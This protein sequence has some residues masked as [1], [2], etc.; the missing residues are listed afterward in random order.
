MNGVVLLLLD[1]CGRN[2]FAIHASAFFTRWRRG[3]ASVTA[4]PSALVRADLAGTS[5]PTSRHDGFEWLCVLSGRLRVVLGEADLS[6]GVGEAV[7][8]DTQ[9]PYWFGS[10][11]DGPVEVLSIFGRPG[12]RVLLRGAVVGRWSTGVGVPPPGAPCGRMSES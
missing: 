3:R 2:A 4:L 11:G 5:R 9:V 8:F 7:E 12:E 10:T 1:G 6:L